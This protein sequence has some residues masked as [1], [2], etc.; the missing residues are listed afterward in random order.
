M[1]VVYLVEMMVDDSVAKKV[2]CWVST[3]VDKLE[4]WMVVLLE[5]SKV[6][7]RAQLKEL[8]LAVSLACKLVETKVEKMA[9]M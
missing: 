9:L 2:T 3:S 1:S 7:L 8:W 5:T 4:Y 6:E